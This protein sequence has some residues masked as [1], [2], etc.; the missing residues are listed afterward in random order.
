MF[1]QPARLTPAAVAVEPGTGRVLAYYGGADGAGMDHAGVYVDEEGQVAGY[2]Y[3]PPGGTFLVH[4]LAAAL[5]LGISLRSY[6]VH[7]PHDQP[8]RPRQNPIRNSGVCPSD[9]LRLGACSLIGSTTASLNVPFYD[10]TVAVSPAKVLELARDAGIDAM[11][12]D[13]RVRQDLAT[14]NMVSLTPSKFDIILGLGQYPVTVVDQANAMATYAA[15]GLRAKAHFVAE[16]RERG[17]V[18]Y[19]ET[20]PAPQ[21]PRVLSSGAAAD[22]SWVLSESGRQLGI[23]GALK[24]GV[25][26]YNNRTDQNAHAWAVGYTSALAFAVWVGNQ[27]EEAALIDRT[28]A[29]IWGSGL[30]SQIF[31]DFMTEAQEALNLHPQ[32]FPP[33]VFGGRTDP[34]LSAPR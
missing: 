31:R 26:E 13:D 30:P 3:H 8:G 6:W 11:W 25:W 7:T 28:G 32:P 34:P 23:D 1:G 15:A 10:V 16:V 33:P 27:A 9:Q 22:L 17:K 12:T 20:L 5:N 4:T 2:G 18:L 24:T 21:Q 29:T 14:A 19:A